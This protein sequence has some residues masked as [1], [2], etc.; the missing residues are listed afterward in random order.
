MDDNNNNPVP[1]DNKPPEENNPVENDNDTVERLETLE[2]E[3]EAAKKARVAAEKALD[4]TKS[5]NS[6]LKNASKQQ[7]TAAEEI[8]EM[9]KELAAE[10]AELQRR[11]N[12]TAAKEALSGLGL[13]DKDMTD[14]E[15][16][17][18]VSS[19]EART[20]ARCSYFASFVKKREAAAAKAEREK[21]LKETPTP[22]GGD[23]GKEPDD[24]FLQGFNSNKYY[25]FK[26]G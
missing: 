11:T 1:E 7:M 19:D 18:F 23:G 26:K 15:L 17:L 24:A 4:L 20:S 9:K 22:P 6:K 5:E 14:E 13:S 3:L 2:R 12:R 10:R 25:E 16:E 8:E 21:V